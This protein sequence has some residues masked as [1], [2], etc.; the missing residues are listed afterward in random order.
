MNSEIKKSL[1]K[2]FQAKTPKHACKNEEER[3]LHDEL[4]DL[5][6]AMIDLRKRWNQIDVEFEHYMTEPVM[7]FSLRLLH[8]SDFGRHACSDKYRLKYYRKHHAREMRFM[9]LSEDLKRP[10]PCPTQ[11]KLSYELKRL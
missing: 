7:A 11:D 2:S 3:R 9:E 10:K 6:D 1:K 4:V 5:V 8:K